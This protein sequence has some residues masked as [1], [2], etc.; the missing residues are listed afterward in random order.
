MKEHVKPEKLAF[1][2]LKNN[3]NWLRYSSLNILIS[4]A[5]RAWQHQYSNITSALGLIIT[6]VF[7]NNHIPQLISK[8][9]SIRS[10][11]GLSVQ[12]F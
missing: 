12:F 9:K 10:N 1:V 2:E 8:K 6:S 4:P 11:F 7:L 3:E 5:C